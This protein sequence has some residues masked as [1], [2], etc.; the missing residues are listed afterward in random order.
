[1]QVKHDAIEFH[2]GLRH[3]PDL[4]DST[5]L[6]SP[7]GLE[8]RLDLNQVDP[9][10]PIE[11]IDAEDSVQPSNVTV[12]VHSADQQQ[13]MQPVAQL[14]PEPEL[15]SNDSSNDE[16]SVLRSMKSVSSQGCVKLQVSLQW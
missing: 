3:V 7:E 11:V 15:S 1:M 6:E 13:A 12:E 9:Q 4:D 14:A 16:R 2:R 8:E 5:W 10:Q